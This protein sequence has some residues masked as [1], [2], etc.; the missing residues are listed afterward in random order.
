MYRQH[1]TGSTTMRLAHFLLAL[2]THPR[3]MAELIYLDYN[4]TTPLAPEVALGW[5]AW[6]SRSWRSVPTPPPDHAPAHA[7]R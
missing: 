6:Q 7:L 3:R 2:A 1:V 4:A 5:V